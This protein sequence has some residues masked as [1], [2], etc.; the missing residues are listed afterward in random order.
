[1][2]AVRLR[3]G[4]LTTIPARGGSESLELRLRQAGCLGSVI[5]G[6]PLSG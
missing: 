2:G 1:M 3:A 5:S 6:G 4:K